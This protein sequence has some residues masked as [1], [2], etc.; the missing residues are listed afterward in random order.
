MIYCLV[1]AID[2]SRWRWWAGFAASD[3]P[4]SMPIPAAFM[5]VVVANLC[6]AIALLLRHSTAD[7]RIRYFPRLIVASVVLSWFTS[8]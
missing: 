1:Q 6:G 5:L 7:E 4:C 8:S 2:S 3:L